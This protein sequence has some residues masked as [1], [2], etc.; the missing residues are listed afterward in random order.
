MAGSFVTS[1]DG[2]ARRRLNCVNHQRPSNVDSLTLAGLIRASEVLGAFLV[3][4]LILRSGM[5]QVH[6]RVGWVDP[7]LYIYNFLSLP[8][9]MA[10]SASTPVGS[11]YHFSRLPFVLPG[12]AIYRV[13][14]PVRAQAA[15]ITAFFVLGLAGLFAVSRTLVSSVAG[16]LALVWV[17]ALNP[18]WMD[19]FVEGYV[20]GPAMAFA[21]FSF[22]ALASR[23]PR[24]LGVPR[25]FWAGVSVA[26]ALSTQLWNEGALS[27]IID[28]VISGNIKQVEQYKSGKTAVLGFLVGQVMKGSR[29]RADPAAVNRMLKERLN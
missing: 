20:D 13:L 22:A 3:P 18:L 10:R 5:Y 1:G 12:Y 8:E 6:P 9:N 26:L 29:G 7:G 4:I 2:W 15:L 28:E 24:L 23:Q 14:E 11:A 27:A 19:A 25:P 17:V 21:L 16:R